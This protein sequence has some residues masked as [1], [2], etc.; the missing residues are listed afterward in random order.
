MGNK[1]ED[2]LYITLIDFFLQI[3]FLVLMALMFYI[4]IQQSNLK[5]LEEAA[6]ISKQSQQWED[7]AKKY[8]IKNVQNLLDTLMTLAPIKNLEEAKTAKALVDGYGGLVA[9]E[10]IL[11]KSKEGQGKPSCAIHANGVRKIIATFL[12]K[13]TSITLIN[14]QPEL[15]ALA[16]S[17]GKEELQSNT[18]WR[19]QEF[20]D[21]W[22]GVLIKHPECRYSVSIKEETELKK[23]LRTIENIFYR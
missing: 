6:L 17:L 4:A 14:W 3:L 7:L 9:V 16:K 23:P 11:K 2:V 5:K 21:Y 15:A 20:T 1:R 19:L 8:D 10:A 13:D 22:R 12:A 18:Q